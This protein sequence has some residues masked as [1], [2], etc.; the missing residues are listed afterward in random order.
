MKNLITNEN[1]EYLTVVC[2]EL[3]TDGNMM[4]VEILANLNPENEIN[5]YDA[6]V[7]SFESSSL[8]E[9]FSANQIILNYSKFN[10]YLKERDIESAIYI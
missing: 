7:D 10:Q 5:N 6:K 4:K 8:R 9:A 2:E 1:W 3:E